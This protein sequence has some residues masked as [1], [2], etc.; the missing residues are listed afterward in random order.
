MIPVMV[1]RELGARKGAKTNNQDL[2]V[3]A[4]REFVRKVNNSNLIIT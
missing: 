3:W 2:K 4:G 1:P